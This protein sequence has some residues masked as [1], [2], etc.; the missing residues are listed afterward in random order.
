METTLHGGVVGLVLDTRGR[1]PFVL[2]MEASE[3]IPLLNKWMLAL[4]AYPEEFLK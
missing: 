2:P 1:R 4:K 3:R